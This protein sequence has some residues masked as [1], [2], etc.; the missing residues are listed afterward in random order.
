MNKKNKI[1][2]TKNELYEYA[3]LLLGTK[4]FIGILLVLNKKLEV[5]KMFRQRPGQ[6]RYGISHTMDSKP[7]LKGIS[8]P[9]CIYMDRT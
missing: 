4:M 5:T 9:T 7:E 1:R 2:H 3:I 6:I 8:G